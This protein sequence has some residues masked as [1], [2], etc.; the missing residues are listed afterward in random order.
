M[1]TKKLTCI[2]TG[3]VLTANLDYYNKK[4]EKFKSEEELISTYI[5]KEAKDLLEQGFTVEQIR[6]Q[7]NT[8]KTFPLPDKKLINDLFVNAYGLKK[9]TVFSAVSSLTINNTDPE[10]KQFLN[11]IL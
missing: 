10:V 4:L 7:F 6:T 11:K 5:C 3:K 1:K 2:V 9:E 8:P